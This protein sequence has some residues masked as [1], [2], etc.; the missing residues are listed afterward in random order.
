MIKNNQSVHKKRIES[1]FSGK[2]PDRIP[3]CEQAF[4]STVASKILGHESLTG[5]T[6]LHYYESCAWL[7][8]E[9][10]HSEFV[11]KCYTDIVELHKKLDFDILFLP[12]MMHEKPSKR[13]DDSRIL[14]SS[15][16]DD[17]WSICKFDQKS[18]TYG[19]EQTSDQFDSYE[20]VDVFIRKTIN[21]FNPADI[22]PAVDPL[23][24]RAIREYGDEFEIAGSSGFAIP[25]QTGWLEAVAIDPELVSTYIDIKVEEQLKNI[26]A[27]Y[28]AGIRLINGGGDFAFN[29]GPI[30]SPFFFQ[31]YIAPKWKRVFD[32]CH[33]LGMYYIFRSDGFLWPVSD[34]LFGKKLA[35]AYY[36]VD[37]DAG[38]HFDDLRKN[39]P[40]LVLFGNVSCDL[41]VNGTIEQIK[42]RALECITA[43]YPRLVLG[44]SN[45]ILHGSPVENVLAIYETARNY[46][47]KN[48]ISESVDI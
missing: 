39:Y 7:L 9:S 46:R 8:G 14:Y 43:A 2:E 6:D 44:S 24:L 35:D 40:D 5:S 36:E 29:S 22:N 34:H 41:I 26:E 4:S 15:K 13:I 27:Q 11:D 48:K 10:A 1:V 18:H 12:W 33:E 16:N 42:D 19:V 17:S 20:E 32:K 28:N 21:E 25:V 3:L 23:L 31:K 47:S 45:S 30:Y 38:M 37:Y